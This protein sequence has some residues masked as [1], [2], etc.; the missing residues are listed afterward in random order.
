MELVD[1]DGVV[2]R[3]SY[4]ESMRVYL[5]RI[6]SAPWR[7]T[8][9]SVV[10]A[11]V[12][13]C[14]KRIEQLR[15]SYLMRCQDIGAHMARGQHTEQQR[16][17]G[18]GI[19]LL[20]EQL[21]ETTGGRGQRP[22]QQALNAYR[23]DIVQAEDPAVYQVEHGDNG[24]IFLL[25]IFGKDGDSSE[26]SPEYDEHVETFRASERMGGDRFER[27]FVARKGEVADFIITRRM[28][29]ADGGN[30]SDT[31]LDDLP[32]RESWDS[33]EALPSRWQDEHGDLASPAGASAFSAGLVELRRR[34][35]TGA[36]QNFKIAVED[37]PY[38]REAYLALST[39]LDTAG[40]VEEGEMYG[41]MAAAYLPDDG[42]VR[43]N[44]G[45]NLLRQRRRI[46]ALEAFEEAI[47]R[48]ATLFQP[49]YFAGLIYASEGKLRSALEQFGEALE[50]ADQDDKPRIQAALRWAQRRHRARRRFLGAAAASLLCALGMVPWVPWL[51]ILPG[52]LAVALL[53]ANRVH[54]RLARS[55]LMENPLAIVSPKTSSK[56]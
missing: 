22:L 18:E 41:A 9:D 52:V 39:L 16:V 24:S 27:V 19:N 37:N 28:A 11:E 29:V 14:N 36:I 6:A 17:I 46:E 10:A 35:T 38:H 34:N 25:Y 54:A 45:L 3:Y 50:R 8:D 30:R 53:G 44:Q 21:G 55:W 4:D 15:R 31:P 42:L 51:A 43:F 40:Q 1:R 13:H 26:S 56:K 48:D 7:Y 20:Q 5:R 47:R 12:D 32:G 23:L 2:R 33:E 49:R